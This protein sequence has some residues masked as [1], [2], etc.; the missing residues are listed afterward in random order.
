MILL[1]DENRM[2]EPWAP[3]SLFFIALLQYAF[4]VRGLSYRFFLKKRRAFLYMMPSASSSDSPCS[5]KNP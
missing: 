5:R 2:Q 1:K 3:A 4:A